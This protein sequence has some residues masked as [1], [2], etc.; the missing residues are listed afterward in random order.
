MWKKTLNCTVRIVFITFLNTHFL[1]KAQFS[2][3]QNKYFDTWYLCLYKYY[4]NIYFF[5]EVFLFYFPKYAF[6]KT[7]SN[8]V[9][10]A[11]LL[12]SCLHLMSL[13]LIGRESSHQKLSIM[14]KESVA[15]ASRAS[16]SDDTFIYIDECRIEEQTY[17]ATLVGITLNHQHSFFLLMNCL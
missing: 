7:I 12:W 8:G 15:L 11:S 5:I 2:L 14:W 3:V 6:Q 10:P 16:I 13:Y 4:E 9:W 1:W 17:L